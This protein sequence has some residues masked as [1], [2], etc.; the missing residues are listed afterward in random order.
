MSFTLIQERAVKAA[1]KEHICI[2]CGQKIP[3]GTPY[4]YERSIFENEPQSHHWHP[5]CLDAMHELALDNG[6]ESTFTAFDNERP[7]LETGESQ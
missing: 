5:E 3:V 4:T 2:W 7:Q 6:G 1:R